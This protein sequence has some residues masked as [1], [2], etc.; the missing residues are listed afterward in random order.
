MWIFIDGIDYNS[1]FK[2][3]NNPNAVTI[4]ESFKSSFSHLIPSSMFFCFLRNK[5][6]STKIIFTFLFI[7]IQGCLSTSKISDFP[8]SANSFDFQ[9]I[10]GSVKSEEDKK[11]NS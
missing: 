10:A 11:W 6:N 5:I 4:V 7:T 2:K 3:L 9:K 1:N 8:K